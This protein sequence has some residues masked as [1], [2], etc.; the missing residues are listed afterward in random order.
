M[1]SSFSTSWKHIRR[2]P[3]QAL[4]AI[5]V[6]T[7]TLFIASIFSLVSY[8]TH[9]ILTYFETRPQVTAFFED[10]A[11]DEDIN[12]LKSE[13]ESKEFV[14]NTKFVS[15]EEALAI[16]R[17]QN[18]DD[19]L[20]LEM[21]TADILP[22][23]L[24]ASGISAD[25]LPQ[26]ADIMTNRPGVEEVV[27]QKDVIEALRS[28]ANAIRTGGLALVGFLILTSILILV[29]IISMKIAIRRQEIEILNLMGASGWYIKNPFIV[30]GAI[31]G[32][33]SSIFAWG[34]SYIGL[35]Y[36]T[37]FLVSFLGNIPLLPVKIELMLALLGTE[38]LLGIII[39]SLGSLIAV[40]RFLRTR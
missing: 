39:G 25:V 6:L 26:I 37:P 40:R 32:I 24:E 21:V 29:I 5:S 31:Y 11:T 20:L 2:T 15:K 34:L 13:L 14:A 30:E 35:L 28:W 38:V 18:K 27:Y 33:I 22:A 36:A 7:L 10:T 1:A 17:E 19:P 16:Y 9:Q 3:Y 23:S 4:A 8:G 12:R